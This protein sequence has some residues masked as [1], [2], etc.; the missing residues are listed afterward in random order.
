[1]AANL[2]TPHLPTY[3]IYLLQVLL[4]LG[5]QITQFFLNQLHNPLNPYMLSSTNLI[6]QTHSLVRSQ[7][8]LLFSLLQDGADI[9]LT[10]IQVN[11][12]V[13]TD[14]PP[15]RYDYKTGDYFP[16]TSREQNIHLVPSLFM[17]GNTSPFTA[18]FSSRDTKELFH[19]LLF[20]YNET[21]GSVSPQSSLSRSLSYDQ[22]P[23]FTPLFLNTSHRPPL[24]PFHS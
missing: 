3:R 2:P 22:S 11:R 21:I 14:N 5:T 16:K 23:I 19:N 20:V 13:R 1:M 6:S 8:P 9:N 17:A 4:N 7:F 10:G 12:Y 24:T 18:W 15:F